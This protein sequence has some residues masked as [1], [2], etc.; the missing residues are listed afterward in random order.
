MS[1]DDYVSNGAWLRSASRID[2]ID[3]MAH[4]FERPVVADAEAFWTVG[5]G[6]RW[7]RSSP[8]SRSM[9]LL[10]PQPARSRV[11]G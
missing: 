8:G 2:A 7:P 3:V 9:G 10:H 1:D 6:T 5:S 11:S 4:Q